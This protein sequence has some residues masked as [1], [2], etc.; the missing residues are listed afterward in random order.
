LRDTLRYSSTETTLVATLGNL[1]LYCGFLIGIIYDKTGPRWTSLVSGTMIFTGYFMTWLALKEYIPGP[2]WLVA[3]FYIFVGQGSWG[4]YEVALLTNIKN[5]QKNIGKVTGVLASAFGLSGGMFTLIY[6]T[7]F[8]ASD[9]VEGF[10]LLTS[11]VGASA[12]VLGILVM[13]IIPEEEGALLL[14]HEDKET[15]YTSETEKIPLSPEMNES[16]SSDLSSPTL[17][18]KSPEVVDIS[19]IQLFMQLDFWLL[20]FS[21]LFAAGAGLMLI[22]HLGEVVLSTGGTKADKNILVGLLSASNCAGR[23]SVGF[24]SDRL[25]NKINRAY[26]FFFGAVLMGCTHL[27]FAALTQDWWVAVTTL[28]TGFAYGGIFAVVPVLVSLYFGFKNLG[29]NF[30]FVSLAPACGS[31]ALGQLAGYLYD[32]QADKEGNHDVGAVDDDEDNDRCYGSSC[33]N[34]A[35]LVSGSLCL[36]AA[37]I[38][39]TLAIRRGER[40]LRD[41][42][43]C[44]RDRG[45]RLLE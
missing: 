19:G 42:I 38:A 13:K 8:S 34:I 18:T 44:I 33:Y 29:L 9:N 43:T 39:L 24:F 1:G 35:F 6:A 11:I 32:R 4:L 3:I 37:V 40:H 15:G 12:G 25:S 30:G 5:F 36:L 23:L 31:I 10:I 7:G 16:T 17:A 14:Q 27:T 22:N 20:W 26:W 21:F 28:G 45:K 41:I 2:A